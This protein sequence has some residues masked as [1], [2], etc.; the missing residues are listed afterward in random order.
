MTKDKLSKVYL[1][2]INKEATEEELRDF[3][4]DN[5]IG[6]KQITGLWLKKGFAFID[7]ADQSSADA[8]IDTLQHREFMGHKLTLEPSVAPGINSVLRSRIISGD[9]NA[10]IDIAPSVSSDTL[11]ILIPSEFVGAIIG[12]G[13]AN[14]KELTTATG[15]RINILRNKPHVATLEKTVCIIGSPER[16]T[17][18]CRKILEICEAEGAALKES[19]EVTLKILANN[20]LIGKIIGKDGRNI[21]KLMQDT[22]TKIHVSNQVQSESLEA[23]ISNPMNV[24]RVITVRGSVEGMSMAEALISAKLKTGPGELYSQALTSLMPPP[25]LYPLVMYPTL[26]YDR[27]SINMDY[28]LRRLGGFNTKNKNSRVRLV[29][30]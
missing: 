9:N 6:E 20:S 3:I 28:G 22:Q 7:C 1:G 13:G 8:L 12:R 23:N 5:G 16:C 21:K 17:A 27:P 10:N 4:Y 26:R 15:A 11:K 14:I 30:A 25:G 24:E 2:N 19:K 18:A 29:R